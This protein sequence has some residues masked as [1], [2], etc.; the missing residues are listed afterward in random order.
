MVIR[1]G[2]NQTETKNGYPAQATALIAD[3]S[4]RHIIILRGIPRPSG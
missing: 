2:S 4:D 3:M 1:S